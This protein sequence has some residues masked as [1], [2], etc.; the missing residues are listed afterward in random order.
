MYKKIFNLFTF[1]T[2]TFAHIFM[3]YP[4]SRHSKYSQ[5]YVSNNL[6]NY[7]LMAPLLAG[8]DFF[9]FPCKGFKKGPSTVTF[10]DN[11]IR[12]TLEGTATHGGGHCQF[13]ITY[14]D[15]TFIVLK[16][17]METCLIDGM[18]YTFNLPS[19]TPSGEVT[20]FW[21]WINKIGNRE[22]YME[23]ADVNIHNGNTN[24]NVVLT[25]LELAIAN[26]P[27]YPIIPEYPEWNTY[28]GKDLFDKRKIISYNPQNMNSPITDIPTQTIP[29]Q[30]H[31]TTIYYHT[32][33]VTSSVDNCDCKNIDNGSDE[34]NEPDGPNAS[35]DVCTNGYMKCVSN[36]YSICNNGNW[37]NMNCPDG[38]KCRT[39]E[40]NYIICDFS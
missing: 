27:G 26:L 5:Y 1:A 28:N 6:V 7:N 35:N 18:S 29:E 2:I 39:F 30:T 32:I 38:T 3:S 15:D 33:T 17:V 40:E 16:T 19:N 24:K 13:G 36:D 9:T 20:V 14:D 12:V 8:P 34:S 25:G 31:S 37:L 11:N 4:P 10:N 23:C 22:Y 21:T